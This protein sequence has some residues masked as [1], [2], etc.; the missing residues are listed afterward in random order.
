MGVFV[1]VNGGEFKMNRDSDG[2]SVYNLEQKS[3]LLKT[4]YLLFS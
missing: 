3:L 2:V 4:I 1:E